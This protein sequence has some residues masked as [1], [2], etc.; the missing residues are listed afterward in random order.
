MSKAL[1]IVL[2]LA[3]AIGVAFWALTSMHQPSIPVLSETTPAVVV[4]AAQSTEAKIAAPVLSETTPAVVVPAAQST[5]AK[6]AAPVVPETTPAVVVPAAQSTEAKIAAPVVPE[7]TPA[8]VVPAAQS[9]L[10]A[11]HEIA[12]GLTRASAIDKIGTK[13]DDSIVNRLVTT[14][15]GGGAL[16][17]FGSLIMT[18]ELVI[19]SWGT[20]DAT[21]YW[22]IWED[23]VYHQPPDGDIHVLFNSDGFCIAAIADLSPTYLERRFPAWTEEQCTQVATGALALGMTGEM[24]EIAWGKPSDV[25]RSV[26]SWGVREQWVYGSD[27]S[28]FF[29]N[30]ILASWTE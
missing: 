1:L 2:G 23:Y 24:A 10:I 11:S 8:V 28:I 14:G 30:G 19:A 25:K 18:R 22:K 6:I 29:E 12:P 13:T 21:E 3:V 9:T 7:T 4:P 16:F 27:T 5:E 26:G 17:F 15:R 20:P